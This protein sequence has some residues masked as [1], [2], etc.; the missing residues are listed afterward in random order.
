MKLRALTPADAWPDDWKYLLGDGPIAVGVDPATT[1]KKLS[2][3]TGL[4]VTQREGLDYVVRAAIRFKTNDPAVTRA[5]IDRAIDL[6][7]N[8]R[9]RRVVILAT[10]ERFFA[11]DERSRLAGR[12]P[13]DLVIESERVS[14]MGEEMTYKLYLGN[15]VVNTFNDNRI[16]APNA[17]WLRNDLRQP[18]G[19]TFIAE[20]DEN[21]NHADAFCALGASLH[22]LIAAGGP[23]TATAVPLSSIGAPPVLRAGLKNPLAHL[24]PKR[25]AI[26]TSLI[27]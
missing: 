27:R 22:G 10:S 4:V 21:G 13:V 25:Y 2:N 12:V 15:L 24:F 3:P 16:A 19:A 20:P 7:N 17:V 5:F 14:Y 9:V 1:T 23:V 18:E 8:K 11:T 26:N 6:P